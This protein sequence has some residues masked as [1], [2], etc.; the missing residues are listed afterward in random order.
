MKRKTYRTIRRLN[1]IAVYFYVISTIGH[2]RKNWATDFARLAKISENNL[3]QMLYRGC[4]ERSA[5]DIITAY[6]NSDRPC[7][8]W[9]F[10]QTGRGDTV[11]N[12][13]CHTTSP[14]F[15]VMEDPLDR[16]MYVEWIDD[17]EH[18]TGLWEHLVTAIRKVRTTMQMGP[19][20]PDAP[21]EARWEE[22]YDYD[23]RFDGHDPWYVF[24]GSP[25]FVVRP[26]QRQRVKW[27]EPLPGDRR[28]EWVRLRDTVIHTFDPRFIVRGSRVEWLDQ[29]MDARDAWEHLREALGRPAGWCCLGDWAVHPRAV[30]APGGQWVWFDAPDDTEELLRIV[31]EYN[32]TTPS[33]PSL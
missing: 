1:T 28:T 24:T 22:L 32:M 2:G 8:E 27:L 14:R 11:R 25:R 17:P 33:T 26:G 13:V 16:S 23:T 9:V 21:D 10:I 30:V 29:P 3:R 12:G 19:T 20:L 15:I 6:Q 5:A 7:D 31:A 18:E 4:S